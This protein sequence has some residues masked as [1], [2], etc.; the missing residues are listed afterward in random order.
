M[1]CDIVR[2]EHT[3]EQL[4]G[5]KTCTWNSLFSPPRREPTKC[6]GGDGEPS[7]IVKICPANSKTGAGVHEMLSDARAPARLLGLRKRGS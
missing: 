1:L 7:K 4:H 2:A 3:S 5:G 6:S